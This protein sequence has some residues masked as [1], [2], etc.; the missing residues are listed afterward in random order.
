MRAS[1]V[2]MVAAFV[3]IAG[4]TAV[5]ATSQQDI[6][7]TWPDQGRPDKLL[8]GRTTVSAGIQRDSDSWCCQ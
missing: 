1:L 4:G 3:L 6:G 2:A 7:G 8:Q 5:A